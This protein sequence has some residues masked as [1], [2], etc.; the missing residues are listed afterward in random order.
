MCYLRGLYF[1]ARMNRLIYPDWQTHITVDGDTWLMFKPY[2]EALVKLFDVK[3]RTRN[4][5]P[6]CEAMLWRMLP[7]F[8]GEYTHV[9]CRDA[10]SIT[11]YR[12]AQAVNEWELSQMGFHGITDNPAHTQ[13]MMGGMV[14]FDSF[15]FKES[16]YAWDSFEEMIK[17]CKLSERGSDQVFMR[18]KIYPF[19]RHK[20][21][22]HY[23]SGLAKSDEAIVRT[24]VSM[25][26]PN[27]SPRLWESNLT[28][29][30]IGSAGVVE[31]ELLRF[32]QR[33]DP[34]QYDEFENEFNQICYWK[35]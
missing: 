19:V 29:R 16:F 5:A 10:D 32:F 11:T 22:A 18:E 1:N 4:A 9:L 24:D 28:C 33:F 23:F 12:E 34:N 15:Q 8:D 31:M 13:P 17:D 21:M 14:G 35:R 30:H 3:I 2:F 27:I 25:P 26:V 6:L 7:L 20:M